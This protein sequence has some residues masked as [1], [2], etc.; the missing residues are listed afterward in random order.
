MENTVYYVYDNDSDAWAYRNPLASITLNKDGYGETGQIFNHGRTYTVR[1]SN[2]DGE[3][4]T[5]YLANETD[6]GH[7]YIEHEE[8]R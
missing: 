7:V 4:G 1:E 5:N 8:V 6:I 3:H 2:K